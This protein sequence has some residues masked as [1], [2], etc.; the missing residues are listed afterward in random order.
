MRISYGMTKCETKDLNLR[1]N[2]NPRM[3]KFGVHKKNQFK[4]NQNTN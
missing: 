2:D 1:A 3:M 4:Y